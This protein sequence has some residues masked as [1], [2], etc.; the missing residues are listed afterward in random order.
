MWLCEMH[1]NR[2]KERKRMFRYLIAVGA[3]LDARDKD[4]LTAWDYARDGASKT[5][6]AFVRREYQRII[7]RTPNRTARRADLP[8]Y[9][10]VSDDA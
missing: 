8:G 6:R 10:H 4:N 2:T 5:F 3:A 9:Q 7:G 1:D